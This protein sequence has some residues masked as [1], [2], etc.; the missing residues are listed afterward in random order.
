[1]RITPPPSAKW[2]TGML[3]K[4]NV[5]DFIRIQILRNY[6][7]NRNKQCLDT[8]YATRRASG[9]PGPILPGEGRT[10]TSVA[11]FNYEIAVLI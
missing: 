11:N 5:F 2:V 10:F 7:I 8:A 3:D 9:Y 1:M 4:Y 6:N